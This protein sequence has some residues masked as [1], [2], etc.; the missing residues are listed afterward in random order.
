MKSKSATRPREKLNPERW[1]QLK[2]ILADA[3]EQD[4]RAARAAL[5]ETRCAHDAVLLAEAESLVQEAEALGHGSTDPMEDC[6][7]HATVT[8]WQEGSAR[9][10]RRIGA[11]LVEGE[12]GHGGMGTVYLAAR[13]DGQFEKQVAIKILKRGTDTDEV[14]RRFAAERHILARL[15]HPNIARLLDAGTTDDGLPYFVM[16]YVA[17]APVTRFVREHKLSIEDRLALFLKICAAVEVAHHNHVI[18]RDLK[19]GNILVNAEGEP[20]LLDFGI[21]KLLTV[22][23]EAG[24]VTAPSEQRLTPICASP[25]QTDGRPITEASDVYALG[26]LLYEMLSGHKPHEFTSAHPSSEEIREVV[27]EQD[28]VP[29]SRRTPDT[30][31]ARQLRGDLDAIV[32][33]ALRKEPERRYATVADLAAEIRRHL[34]RAPILAR[35]PTVGYR[36][37]RLFQRKIVRLIAGAVLVTL[38]IGFLVAL[39]LQPPPTTPAGPAVSDGRKSIAVLPFETLGDNSPP[40]YFADGVQDNILTDLGKVGDLKVISRSGVAAYRGKVRNM[41]QIGR[42]L[43]VANV[44]EGSV[45]LSGDRVRINAQLI[46]TQTDTQVWAEHYDRKV[47]DILALQSELAQTI[48]GQLKATLS[49][50]EKAELWREPTH[51]LEAYGLYLRARASLNEPAGSAADKK[52]EAAVEF[53]NA[54]IARDPKFTLAYCMLNEAH[55]FIYRFGPDRS[56]VHLAAAKSAAETALRLEPDSEDAHLALARYYYH[57]LSDYRR[58]EEELSRISS[59]A[60]H[61]VEFFTMASLAE[62]R[63]GQWADAIRDGEKAVELD[64]QDGGLVV[65][66]IQT[67]SGLRRFADSK[68]LAAAALARLGE[69]APTRLWVVKHEA[70]LGVGNIAEARTALD[71]APDKSDMEYQFARLWL[72]LLERDAGTVQ[73]IAAKAGDEIKEM[74]SF[75]LVLGLSARG[76]GKEEETRHAYGEAK[77][78][79]QESLARRPEMPEVLGT[80][81]SAEAG[82]GEKAEAVRDARRATEILP[83]KVDA[84]S[85]PMGEMRLAEVLAETGDRDGALNKLSEIVKLPFGVNYGDLKLSPAWDTLRDDPRF[86]RILAEAAEPL[87]IQN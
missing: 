40:S 37:Q 68:R 3:L 1:H 87:A 65:N 73:N 19:P 49:S 17:G 72:A 47:E 46:D 20:K 22:G 56:P 61:Q 53:L 18:H 80:L 27:R 70:A 85:G 76:E 29:P 67:Y 86:A 25:E 45:Q 75:W 39:L 31:T 28:P 8:L 71:S 55:V 36:A 43:G 34:L 81:A 82:L 24:E 23:Q 33:Y 52:W 41:K 16:E 66:L 63:L 83:A 9:P 4:S 26:A 6:A 7:E 35:R 11:Y 60:P 5:L 42:E 59:S 32:L 48:A 10:G 44:L 54:A 21:A 14:L 77:R 69:A 79:A 13:A 15:D 2:D 58:T 50:G 74:P 12:L 84:L 78:L 30:Q 64:P 62:R 51:D 38:T 57:G